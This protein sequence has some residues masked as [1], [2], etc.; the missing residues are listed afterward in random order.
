[1][2]F[3]E[4]KSGLVRFSDAIKVGLE[5]CAS[6]TENLLRT[7]DEIEPYHKR[8][9]EIIE[10]MEEGKLSSDDAEN[11]LQQTVSQ[12]MLENI[13]YPSAQNQHKLHSQSLSTILLCCFCLESYINS[14]AYY[15]LKEADLL[16][17]IRQQRKSSV[18]TIL[19][20]IGRL[21]VADKWKTVAK[22]GEHGEFDPSR[23]P[24]QDF[25]ILF[26][27]RDDHVHDKTIRLSQDLAK[28]RYNNKFPDPFAGMLDLGHALYA[29]DVYWNM[30]QELHRVTDADQAE[31]QRLY[32]LSPF[33]NVQQEKALR[34]L[35]EMSQMVLRPSWKL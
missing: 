23:D 32:N 4:R 11:L 25:K 31:F 30:V 35:A 21:N 16:G 27:F 28:E 9:R 33:V 10:Q 8:Q 13:V 12:D 20:A 29:A 19:T 5:E 15:M 24:F 17:F 3:E 22:L 7:H 2:L 34:S 6:L 18:E 1:M 14:F 26:K